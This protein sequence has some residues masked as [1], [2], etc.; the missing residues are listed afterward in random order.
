MPVLEKPPFIK[1]GIFFPLGL[2]GGLPCSDKL[3][4]S[5]N[6]LLTNVN[7]LQVVTECEEKIRFYLEMF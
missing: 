3:R 7:Y 6:C 4:K 5:L 2:L 1:G